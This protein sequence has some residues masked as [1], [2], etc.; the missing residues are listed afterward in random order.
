MEALIHMSYPV[1][2]PSASDALEIRKAMV[3]WRV[4]KVVVDAAMW[5]M[6]PSSIALFTSATGTLPTFTQGVWLWPGIHDM[7]PAIRLTAAQ[8]K[9]CIQVPSH[10]VMAVANCVVGF[11]K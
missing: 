7:K 3:T 2:I 11:Q 9:T 1:E 10:H 6:R 4:D 5:P 8:F